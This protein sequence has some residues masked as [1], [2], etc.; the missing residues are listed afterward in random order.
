MCMLA[1]KANGRV[2]REQKLGK[3][4]LRRTSQQVGT[5][6]TDFQGTDTNSN[7]VITIRFV[8]MNYSR[9]INFFRRHKSNNYFPPMS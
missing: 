3:K 9:V 6:V 2:A 4:K 1:L 5:N 7:Y 8:I